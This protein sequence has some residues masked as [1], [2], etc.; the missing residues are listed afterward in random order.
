MVTG[1]STIHLAEWVVQL[2]VSVWENWDRQILLMV[3]AMVQL[4]QERV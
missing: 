2:L 1:D 3:L 4:P